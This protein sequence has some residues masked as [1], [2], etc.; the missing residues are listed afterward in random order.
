MLQ[1]LD[2]VYLLATRIL[3]SLI[4]VMGLM[5]VT[6]RWSHVR[7][8][9]HRK[10]DW[11]I[12]SLAGATVTINWGVYIW[13]V[14]S[15]HIVDSSLA[16][17]M[18][19]IISIL[20]A[21]IFFHEQLTRLQWSSVVVA[22]IGIVIVVIRFGEFPWL[23]ILIGSTFTLYS[24]LKKLVRVDPFTSMFIETL[25]VLPLALAVILWWTWKG[26]D[27]TAVLPGMKVLLLPAAGLITLVPMLF[28]S[29]GMQRTPLT[30]S[31]LL[32]YINPTMQLLTGVYFYG[33]EFTTTHT[34]LFGFVWGSVAIYLF[35]V[36]RMHQHEKEV[37]ANARDHRLRQRASSEGTGRTGDPSHD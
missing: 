34:I 4:L 5:T 12:L 36:W 15:N 8:L 9:M 28:F 26:L 16:Y 29:Y 25:T 21:A 6:G 20:V 30:I 17:Y 31:G 2:S 1:A 35:S 22:A 33:E 10:R 18:N 14:N 13:A 3:W 27:V 24:T 11:L 19:P 23:A 37:L 7:E 32:M